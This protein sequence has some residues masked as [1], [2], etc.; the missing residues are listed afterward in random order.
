MANFIL[1]IDR[2]VNLYLYFVVMACFLSLVPNINMDYPLF[3]YIFMFAG[4]YFVPPVFGI[5]F[6]PMV[7]MVVLVLISMGL[8]KIYIRYYADKKPKII[9]L[10]QDELIKKL[11]EQKQKGDGEKDDS[12]QNIKS[13][14]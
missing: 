8:R 13:D 14:L 4:F 5:S 11:N 9:V 1:F 6:S 3:H 2:L 12:N 10:T 7:V